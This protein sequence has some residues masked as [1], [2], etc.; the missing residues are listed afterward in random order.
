[1]NLIQIL[2]AIALINQ[3]LP[4]GAALIATMKHPDGTSTVLNDLDEAQAQN[5]INI[6]KAEAFIAA[7]SGK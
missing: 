5:D 6:A 4:A 2:N 3:T 7:H 1:M